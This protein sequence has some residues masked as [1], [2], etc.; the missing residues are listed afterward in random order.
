MRECDRLEHLSETILAYQRALRSEPATWHDAATLLH[1]ILEHRGDLAPAAMPTGL[2]VWADADSVRVIV[3]NLLDN[4]AKYG[5]STSTR[6]TH[7]RR[8]SEWHL[9]ISDGGV[10][11]PPADAERLFD[12]FTR[13]PGTTGHH[14]SGLGLYIA[15]QLAAQMGGALNAASDGPGKGARF[16]LVLRVQ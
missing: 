1:D 12:V 2:Q 16:T 10:G 8:E 5:D 15:R 14:G 7:E 6:I 3:E 9:H 13:G 11:F 4:A